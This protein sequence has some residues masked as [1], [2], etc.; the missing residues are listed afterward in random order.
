M[1][2]VWSNH[3]V[4]PSRD[5]HH[6]GRATETPARQT[7]DVSR[8]E[9]KEGARGCCVQTVNRGKNILSKK[10]VYGCLC[11]YLKHKVKSLKSFTKSGNKEQPK[12]VP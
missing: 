8:E 6:R 7:V 9:K 10:Y 11:Y 5:M 4:D 1:L 3:R 2:G 12:L